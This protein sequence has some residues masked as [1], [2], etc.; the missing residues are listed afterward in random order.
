LGV[1][2]FLVILIIAVWLYAVVIGF[3]ARRQ[4][5]VDLGA[6]SPQDVRAAIP[7]I[8]GKSWKPVEG[9]GEFNYQRRGISGIGGLGKAKPILSITVDETDGR[10]AVGLWMAAW[11]TQAGVIA[12]SDL[13]Q[14]TRARVVRGLLEKF[15]PPAAETVGDA[16]IAES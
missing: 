1:I 15:A 16:A 7:A 13:L 9:K 4:V 3:L 14:F 11:V 8:V 12:G 5:S 10:T 6:V 2:V